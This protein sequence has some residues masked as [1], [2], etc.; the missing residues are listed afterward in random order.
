MDEKVVLLVAFH[1]PPAAMS[2]GH[3]RTLAFAKYL[4]EFGWS[5]VVLSAHSLAYPSTAQANLAAIPAGVTVRRAWALDAGRHL[6]LGGKYP[7]FLAQ[8]DRWISWWPDGVRQGLQAIR[9]RRVRAIWSTYPIMSAHCIAHT[10]SHRAK[11]PWVADF[12]DPVRSSVT[13]DNR[14]AVASQLRWEQKVLQSAACV[15]FTTPGACR[16][17]AE[18][19]PAAASRLTVI[20]NGYD[21]AQFT[22]LVPS[23]RRDGGAQLWVHSGL[24]YPDGRDPLPFFAALAKLKSVGVLTAGRLQVVLRASGFEAGYAR[25]IARLGLEDLVTLAP[26]VSN[27]DA[28]VEQSSA[29]ALL[30]FQGRRFNRQVP[31]K[32]YEYLRIGRPI[33]A[34][35]DT[36]GDTAAT[37]RA[38]GGAM[39]AAPD[40][41][42]AIADAAQRFMQAVANGHPPR[43]DAG[44]VAGYSRR[45][46]AKALAEMLDG[47]SATEYASSRQ[48]TGLA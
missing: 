32:M 5:P 17:Y 1:F 19:Y 3:L 38:S 35:V 6:S 27:R 41:V 14:F 40:D 37:L 20:A 29:D 4:P 46:G 25:E 39:I 24:L 22:H 2:S 12:R 45:A 15:T 9:Q 34:L 10:L 47:L 44:I 13:P 8:P 28:L 18:R 36:D 21:E 30:L 11:V 16:E 33:L 48:A 26:P 23:A 7:G 43:A 31:A 42:D